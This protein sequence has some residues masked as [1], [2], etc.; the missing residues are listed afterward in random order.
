MTKEQFEQFAKEP[1][2]L[3]DYCREFTAIM[4]ELKSA[5]EKMLALFRKNGIDVPDNIRLRELGG[6]GYVA[7]LEK[8]LAEQQ[9]V[10]I[11]LT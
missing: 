7:A 4:D 11:W 6:Y 10:E 3:G 1:G 9:G 8:K 2:P 5:K